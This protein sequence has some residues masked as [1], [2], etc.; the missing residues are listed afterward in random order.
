MA[1]I[2]QGIISPI[3]RNEAHRN[4]FMHMALNC[5][6]ICPTLYKMSR[7]LNDIKITNNANRSLTHDI[8]AR[9]QYISFCIMLWLFP[10]SFH[11]LLVCYYHLKLRSMTKT[12][13]CNIPHY[14]GMGL[15]IL[16]NYIDILK[17]RLRLMRIR[18]GF[19]SSFYCQSMLQIWPQ[20]TSTNSFLYLHDCCK[21]IFR[22]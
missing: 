17:K 21:V 12:L 2:R 14:Y 10:H 4:S 5:V 15:L 19:W 22:D 9:Q 13:A 7:V 16:T 8:F 3:L 18:N 6:M 20:I 11:M 1:R